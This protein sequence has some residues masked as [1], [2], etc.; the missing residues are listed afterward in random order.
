MTYA[1]DECHRMR[2][3]EICTQG[4]THRMVVPAPPVLAAF[5]LPGNCMRLFFPPGAAPATASPASAPVTLWRLSCVARVSSQSGK[6]AGG[7]ADHKEE[8]GRTAVA[9]QTRPTRPRTAAPTRVLPS[10][11]LQLRAPRGVSP[12]GPAAASAAAAGELP[13]PRNGPCQSA[14]HCGERNTASKLS[15][16]TAQKRETSAGTAASKGAHTQFPLL[17]L[18]RPSLRSLLRALEWSS[19]VVAR[20]QTRAHSRRRHTVVHGKLRTVASVTV[21]GPSSSLS[22]RLALVLPMLP[23]GG[24]VSARAATSLKQAPPPKHSHDG[25]LTRLTV[26]V[27]R[28]SRGATHGRRVCS[29]CGCVHGGRAGE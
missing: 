24:R 9:L 17:R 20:E 22:S 18:L 2:T 3:S 10:L 4:D 23:G 16:L 8:G 21:S 12:Q 19:R 29:P 26:A 11:V 28:A 25:L 6:A 1:T 15:E 27:P 7:R 14:W 13:Q 5:V